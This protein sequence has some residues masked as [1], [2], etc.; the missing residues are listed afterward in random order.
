MLLATSFFF[1][2]TAC[3]TTVY[4]V[5]SIIEPTIEI[6]PVH[7]PWTFT[8]IDESNYLVSQEDLKI[9]ASYIVDLKNYA[10]DGWD[11]VQYYIDE[12]RRIKKDFE[13]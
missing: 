11:S 8:A 7:E 2:L 13:G 10:A 5:P 1:S 12:L 3:K 9:L 4:V 6:E